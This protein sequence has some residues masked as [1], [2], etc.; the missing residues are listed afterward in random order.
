MA[1]TDLT[2]LSQT[3]EPVLH[4][5]RFAAVHCAHIF[6]ECDRRGDAMRALGVF[7]HA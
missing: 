6:V 7:A 1:E 4:V 2:T 3:M 5:E